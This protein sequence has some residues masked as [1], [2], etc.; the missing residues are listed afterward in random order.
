MF[1]T[2]LE[3][4]HKSDSVRFDLWSA[5]TMLGLWADFLKTSGPARKIGPIF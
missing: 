1:W 2:V 3:R 5:F 4:W